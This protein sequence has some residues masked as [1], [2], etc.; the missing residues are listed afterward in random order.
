MRSLRAAAAVLLLLAL[1]VGAAAAQD[2]Y[3][4][5]MW[6]IAEKVACPVCEGQSVKDS[7]AQLAREMR[8]LIVERLRL[9]DDPEAIIDFLAERYGEGILMDPPKTGLGLGVWVGPFIFLAAG[10]G[11]VAYLLTRRPRG[12]SP[13]YADEGTAPQTDEHRAR[14][15]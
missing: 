13:S 5:R 2:P 4:E 6:E 1:S 9:G 8:D 3:E 14:E 11:I 15:G 7:N 12:L 10:I